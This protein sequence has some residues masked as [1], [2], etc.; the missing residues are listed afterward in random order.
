MGAERH[1]QACPEQRPASP[2]QPAAGGAGRGA[3]LTWGSAPLSRLLK[4]KSSEVPP[5]ASKVQAGDDVKG[6]VSRRETV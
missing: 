1:V 6:T 3:T 4:K 5:L 2:A